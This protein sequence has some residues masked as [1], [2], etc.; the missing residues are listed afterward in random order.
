MGEGAGRAMISQPLFLG[1]DL[2]CKAVAVT[3]ALLWNL[4]K[5][6]FI[7]RDL[8]DELTVLGCGFSRLPLIGAL[9]MEGISRLCFLIF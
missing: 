1:H 6:V 2:T 8:Q 7:F 4:H 3:T 5:A 9:Y